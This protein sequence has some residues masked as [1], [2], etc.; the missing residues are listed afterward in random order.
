MT[1]KKREFVQG[2]ITALQTLTILPV[3]GRGAQRMG[4]AL[5]WFPLVGFLLGMLVA[6][7]GLLTIRISAGWSHAAGFVMLAAGIVLTRALHLDGIADWADGFWG[8]FDRARVLAIMKD[9]Q[10]GTF[11]TVALIWLLLGKWMA[12]ARLAAYGGWGWIVGAFVISRTMQVVLAAAH[13]YARTEAGTASPFVTETTV[14]SA[15]WV[16]AEAAILLT[17]VFGLSLSWPLVLAGAWGTTRL[18]GI[19]CVRRVGGVTGDLLGACSELAELGVLFA[20]AI[21]VGVK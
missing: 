21:L 4:A 8:G 3:P 15:I 18:F 13:P 14:S 11:G 1:T 19:W 20:G 6:L 12:L 7:A 9:S 10:L 5:P 16:M 17:I 2:L